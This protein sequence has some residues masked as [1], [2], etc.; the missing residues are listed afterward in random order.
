MDCPVRLY[1]RAKKREL[2]RL[3]PDLNRNK[4]S[5][6]Q[7]QNRGQRTL[8]FCSCP[9]G[10]ECSRWNGSSGSRNIFIAGCYWTIPEWTILILVSSEVFDDTYT[11][12]I[13]NTRLDRLSHEDRKVL[14]TLATQLNDLKNREKNRIFCRNWNGYRY[15]RYLGSLLACWRWDWLPL[16]YSMKT[17]ETGTGMRTSRGL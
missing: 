9:R 10:T 15:H 1:R 16:W 6:E 12:G 5:D 14:D 3:S 13:M 11:A 8:F 4:N 7:L 2:I 17:S